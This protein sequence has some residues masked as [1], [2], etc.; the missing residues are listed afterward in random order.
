MKRFLS[1]FIASSLIFSG[2]VPNVYANNDTIGYDD[3]VSGA[4]IAL[5]EFV[6]VNV[7]SNADMYDIVGATVRVDKDTGSIVWGEMKGNK[8]IIPSTIGGIKITEIADNAFNGEYNCSQWDG[9]EDNSQIAITE[10]IIIEE[11]I[12]RIGNWAFYSTITGGYEK[13]IKFTLPSTLSYIGDIAFGNTGVTSI[14]IPRNVKYIGGNAFMDCDFTT[15]TLPSTVTEIGGGL[16][17]GNNN[18]KNIFVESG[19]PNYSSNNGVMFNKSG[20][21]LIEYPAGKTDARYTVPDNVKTIG[22]VSFYGH[23]YI[24]EVILP[25][26]LKVIG[27]GAFWYCEKLKNINIPNGVEIINSFPFYGCSNVNKIKIPESVTDISNGFINLAY[28]INFDKERTLIFFGLPPKGSVSSGTYIYTE[29][30][31]K[32]YYDKSDAWETIKKSYSDIGSDSAQIVWIP[33]IK[34]DFNNAT[35][36]VSENEHKL[37]GL[38]STSK[39]I[40]IPDA[41]NGVTITNIDDEVFDYCENMET[42]TIPDSVKEIP[43]DTFKNCVNLKQVYCSAQSPANNTALYNGNVSIII[44][45][46]PDVPQNTIKGDI[47]GDGKLSRADLTRLNKYFAGWDVEINESAADVTGDGKIS[48]A[49]LTRLNKYFAGWDVELK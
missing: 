21:T 20:D 32:V 23:S 5:D 48:R 24:E 13:H 39:D 8:V 15:F 31:L 35:A 6:P 26:D 10:E 41:V 3:T 14:S 29:K 43:A 1:V 18:L 37:I 46:Q 17:S 36:Y 34:V 7:Y 19:N 4:A 45:T 11:G 28:A 38:T 2:Y 42:L 25:K 49:D 44:D 33:M 47:T 30:D 22:S 40:K 16:F 27:N 9:R 12:T